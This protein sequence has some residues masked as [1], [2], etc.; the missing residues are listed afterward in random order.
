M[1]I[2]PFHLMLLML[3]HCVIFDRIALHNQCLDYV[4]DLM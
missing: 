2:R 1:P 4:L 3:I